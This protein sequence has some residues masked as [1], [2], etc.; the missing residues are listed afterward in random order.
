[1]ASVSANDSSPVTIST[2]RV[3]WVCC[4]RVMEGRGEREEVKGEGEEERDEEIGTREVKKAST[5]G[6][7]YRGLMCM[8]VLGFVGQS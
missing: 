4:G 7:V 1:M 2:T 6:A 5:P 8:A 3:V